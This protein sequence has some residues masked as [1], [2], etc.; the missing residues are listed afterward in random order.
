M[1][2]VQQGAF[3]LFGLVALDD[4]GLHLD[5]AAHGMLP[6]RD[7]PCRKRRPVD[8]EPVEKGGIAQQAVFHHL[9]VARQEIAHWHGCQQADICQHQGRLMK[10]PDQVLALGR[11]DAGLAADRAVD[12]RQQ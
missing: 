2:E 4:P 7:V 1:P 6:Q 3:A 12:L 10:R 5:R 11:V 9:A 8:L